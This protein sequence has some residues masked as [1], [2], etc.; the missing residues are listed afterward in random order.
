MMKRVMFVA[1]FLLLSCKGAGCE[2]GPS[3]EA[4]RCSTAC[5]SRGMKS[6]KGRVSNGCGT[7]TPD[8]CVCGGPDG[9]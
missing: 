8:E 5:G 3:D 7:D 9:G 4:G 2:F 6:F 1:V